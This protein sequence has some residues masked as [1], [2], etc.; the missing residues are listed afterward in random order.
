VAA[1]KLNTGHF[2]HVQGVT[3]ELKQWDISFWAERLREQR[4]AITDEELRPYFALP[5]VL[6]GLFKVCAGGPLV[7]CAYFY[8]LGR[9]ILKGEVTLW[10]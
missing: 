7:H 3:E 8:F 1:L 5:N 10:S 6:N 4:F 9:M 2:W